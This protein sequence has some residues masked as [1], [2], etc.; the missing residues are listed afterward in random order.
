MTAPRQRPPWWPE[1]EPFPP[2]AGAPWRRFGPGGHAW[3]GRHRRGPRIGCF[4]VLAATVFVS[5]GVLVLW[6]LSLL[7]GPAPG[8]ELGHLVRP[9]AIVLLLVVGLAVLTGARMGPRVVRPVQ[10][11]IAAA[12]RIESGDYA[13]RVGSY[14]GPQEVRELAA[15]FNTMAARLEAEEANRRRLLADLSHELRTPLAVI[16]GHLEAVLDGVY[17]ADAAHLDPILDEAHVL[18]RLI[19][20]LRTLSLAEAGALALHPEATD[21]G[22]LVEDVVAGHRPG[23]DALGAELETA[24]EPGLPELEVDPVRMHQVLSNLLDN[25]I[26]Y[27]PSGGRIRV[28]VE[29]H[30]GWLETAVADQ[31]PGLAPDLRATLFDRFVKGGDSPGSGLGL[32]IAKAI[33]EAHRGRIRADPGPAGPGTVVTFSLPLPGSNPD[34]SGGVFDSSGVR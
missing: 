12:R 20:D 4:L 1:G 6:L 9:G 2:V 5:I 3:R 30:D 33:V 7:L 24:V 32:A 15:A 23:A 17:P 26:R 31:G 25:A 19:D 29:R 8:G 21:M 11:L 27:T 13:A 14:D 28:T 22:H 10:D 34:L 18:D 16:E